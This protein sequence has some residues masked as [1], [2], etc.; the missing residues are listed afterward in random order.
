MKPALLA[1]GLLVVGLALGLGLKSTV[2][3]A[4]AKPP[5]PQPDFVEFIHTFAQ[6]EPVGGAFLS[7]VL[8]TTGCRHIEVFFD[9][10]A[11]ADAFK[12]VVFES[13]DGVNMY[14]LVVIQESGFENQ[15]ISWGSTTIAN[16][17]VISVT[18]T[19]G[20]AGILEEGVVHCVSG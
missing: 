13:T 7:A 17:V 3:E 19:G 2:F 10:S 5:E 15:L 20:A 14:P 6:N 9:F 4:E 12:M 1:I 8:D 18:R 16:S 11:N